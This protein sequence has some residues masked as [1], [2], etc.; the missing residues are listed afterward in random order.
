GFCLS[1]GLDSSTIVGVADRL[2][3]EHDIPQVGDRLK[4]FHSAFD[5]KSIDERDYVR[6]VVNQSRVTPF[7]VFPTGAEFIDDYERLLWHQDEPFGGP[8]VY[9]QYRVIKLAREAG[10]KVLLDGQ[11]G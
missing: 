10:V 8:S 5:D 1:G 9:A 11:G 7:Y 2:L 3:K 6:A 4:V